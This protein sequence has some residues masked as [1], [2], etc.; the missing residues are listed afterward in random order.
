MPYAAAVSLTDLRSRQQSAASCC[1]SSS[2][3]SHYE[4]LGGGGGDN[5]VFGGVARG[6]TAMKMSK[7]ASFN[8]LC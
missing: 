5:I 7:T 4:L 8:S 6:P 2:A 1:S 3:M